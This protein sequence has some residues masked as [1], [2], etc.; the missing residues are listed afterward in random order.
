ML[1]SLHIENI[2]VIEKADVMFNGGFT[3]L[4]GETGAGKSMVI[5]AINAVLGERVSRE[6]VRSGT[7]S[8]L[9]T[10]EFRD[11]S[12]AVTEALASLGYE[13]EE[14]GTLLISRQIGADGRGSCRVGGRPATV[15]VL[16]EVGR[17]L[18]NIHGQH[19][20]QALLVPERHLEYLD[21]M[22]GL[23]PKREAY[24]ARY[25]EYCAL[26]RELRSLNTDE[27]EKTRRI[28]LLSYQI[29]EIEE[30]ALTAGEE[31][32][33][34]EKR[35]LFRHSEKITGAL[36]AAQQFLDGD[37]DTDG[38]ISLISRAVKEIA[39]AAKFSDALQ[40]QAG[41]LETLLFEL[42][43]AGDVLRNT[44]DA[45]S[46]NEQE[47]DAVEQRAELIRRLT[48]KYG[49]DTAAVLAYAEK[50]RQEREQIELADQRREQ[51]ETLLEQAGKAAMDA[52]AE[53]TEAR[54]EAGRIFTE[55]V[56]A[57]LAYLDMPGV[58]L[59]VA[60]E[61]VS[62]TATGGDKIEF[63]IAANPGEPARSIA[64]IASGGELSR[65][66]LAMKSVMADADEIDT[67]IFDEIDAG[68]SGR[69][70][71][72]VGAKLHQIAGGRGGNRQILCVTHLAQIA[73]CAD[74]HLLIQ[75]A[76]KEGRTYT[77]VLPLAQSGREEEL[78][79][80]IGG[81]VTETNLLAAKELLE[82]SC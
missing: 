49:G 23:L 34:E 12:A 38:G 67:L 22:G 2:A 52:A 15:S 54:R 1:V 76:V 66:M 81:V 74:Q 68:I 53:L 16:R 70:A 13:P 64:R 43:A 50:A 3:V 59:E 65:I 20:N 46:F 48:S 9:V 71:R 39:S 27:E 32:A 61:P 24:A 19:E 35:R 40:E 57:E 37:E 41:T 44:Y 8:A 5:D 11:L 82:Q 36:E 6:I 78:A 62:L 60:R 47:R 21:R 72:K 7:A 73:A 28:E 33:L 55:K 14:D 79:R 42:E 69:A 4:T 30:A 26:Y 75:K 58:R 17:M 25:R 77:D 45:L 31:V 80:I 18:V 63:C 29:N 56:A 10:A 51:L